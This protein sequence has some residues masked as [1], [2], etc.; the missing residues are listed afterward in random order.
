MVWKTKPPPKATTKLKKSE[1]MQNIHG[2][3]VSR[4]Q[5][6]NGMKAKMR[7]DFWR[8]ATGEVKYLEKQLPKP[9][10][11]TCRRDEPDYKAVRERY[12]EM[13]FHWQRRTQKMPRRRDTP[14]RTEEAP[15][16]RQQPKQQQSSHPKEGKG[17]ATKHNHKKQKRGGA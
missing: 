5:H 14:D 10:F 9:K 12:D 16:G 4:K 8:K 11:L 6:S 1:L 15:L 17:E 3:I 13:M 7:I 2:K